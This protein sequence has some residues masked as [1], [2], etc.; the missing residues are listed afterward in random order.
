M[1]KVGQL[2]KE[3]KATEEQLSEIGTQ[4][5][6]LTGRLDEARENLALVKSRTEALRKERQGILVD[7]GEPEEATLRLREIKN[8]VDLLEDEIEGITERLS[9]LSEEEGN[10]KIA[11]VD[12]RKTAFKE[13]MI[14]PLVDEYN[15]LAPALAKTLSD[16]D[17]RSHEYVRLFHSAGA[18]LVHSN[19]NTATHTIQSLPALW[20]HGE[21]PKPE[22]YNRINAAKEAALEDLERNLRQMHPDCVC[23]SCGERGEVFQWGE[24]SCKALRGIIPQKIITGRFDLLRGSE[25]SRCVFVLNGTAKLKTKVS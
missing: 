21:D 14:R 22:Y 16:I 3:I 7:G 5:A 17:K 18:K 25:A 4:K 15:H 24:M 12:L 20:M 10:L 19:P 11:L 1:N 23:W 2:N 13:G 9:Y 8:S 6:I